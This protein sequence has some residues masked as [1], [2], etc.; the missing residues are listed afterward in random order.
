MYFRCHSMHTVRHRAAGHGQKFRDMKTAALLCLALAGATF[1]CLVI[2][3]FVCPGPSAAGSGSTAGQGLAKLP[4]PEAKGAATVLPR[5]E[6]YPST[7][8]FS[9]R[10]APVVLASARYGRTYRTR[11]RAGAQTGPNFAGVFTVVSWGC[12]S[13]CQV[14]AIIDARTG[15]LSRQMLRT[16]NGLEFHRDSRLLVADP[17]HPGDPPLETCA[18]CG[19]VAAY[20]WTGASFK[21]V[22]RG[23]HLHLV[24]DRP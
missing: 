8:A 19:V 21:P 7:V 12:G 23:P 10:L 16:T 15:A 9:G 2:A 20:E 24:V 3:G 1:D 4:A 6:D 11:L 14:S 5:F 13:S 22:G 18:A 17:L